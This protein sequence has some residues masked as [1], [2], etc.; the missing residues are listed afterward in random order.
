M[1]IMAIMTRRVVESHDT[2]SIMDWFEDEIGEG[3][4]GILV[5]PN[6]LAFRGIY[7]QYAKNLLVSEGEGQQPKDIS[8]D[9]TNNNNDDKNNNKNSRSKEQKQTLMQPRILLIATFYDTVNTVK[10][11]LSAVGVDVQSHI[12]D[13]SLL[14][15][16][17]FNAY[18][19]DIDGMKKLVASLS[20]RARKEGRAGVSAIVNTGFFFLYGRD[21][22][23]TNLTSYEASLAPKTDGNNVRGF[24]CYHAKNYRKIRDNQ[25]KE[26]LTEGQKKKMLEVIE[27]AVYSM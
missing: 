2:E 8:Q 17:A 13:G 14:I 25:K 6:S 1:S 11:N 26:L 10:H 19:P 27:S 20:E 22:D 18:Y 4:N 24:S 7:T 3:E 16:D 9:N 12:D 23:S 15:V 21:I 5:Y